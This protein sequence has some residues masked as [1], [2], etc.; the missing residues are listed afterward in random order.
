ML[1]YRW[2]CTNKESAE[3]TS[4]LIVAYKQACVSDL[5]I[6]GQR[7]PSGQR[8]PPCGRDSGSAR[9]RHV[10]RSPSV[11]TMRRRCLHCTVDGRAR[12]IEVSPPGQRR[13]SATDKLAR[14]SAP[15]SCAGWPQCTPNSCTRIG[16]ET[17]SAHRIRE[18]NTHPFNG[19]FS[20]TTR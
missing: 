18:R 14:D 17:R 5:R 10:T 1:P 2:K 15:R 4:E 11:E 7:A 12:Q 13:N 19:P 20:G 16:P 6:A 8:T 9:R 3:R